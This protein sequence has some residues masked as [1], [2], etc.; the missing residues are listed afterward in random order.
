MENNPSQK[1][2][3][4]NGSL[5]LAHISDIHF[6]RRVNGDLFTADDNIRREMRHALGEIA[7]TVGRNARNSDYGRRCLRWK[8]RGVQE[9]AYRWIK[10]VCERTGCP[11][12][13]VQRIRGNHD[14]L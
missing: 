11:E 2:S 12:E 4:G 5:I 7:D 9:Q 13:A 10:E 1:L 8:N 6:R 3:E 14:I